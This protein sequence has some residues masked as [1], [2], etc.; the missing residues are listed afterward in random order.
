MLNRIGIF[1]ELHCTC[2]KVGGLAFD[3]LKVMGYC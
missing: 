1:V 3:C 2:I